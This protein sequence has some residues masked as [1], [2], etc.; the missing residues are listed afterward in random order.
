MAAMAG[1]HVLQSLGEKEKECTFLATSWLEYPVPLQ[2]PSPPV[3]TAHKYWAFC[4]HL[5][6]HIGKVFGHSLN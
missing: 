3:L 5:T 1:S 6:Y 4:L 2:L